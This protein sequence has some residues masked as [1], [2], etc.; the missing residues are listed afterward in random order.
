M[1][2]KNLQV[3]QIKIIKM[4]CK[5]PLKVC[6]SYLFKLLKHHLKKWKILQK[7][8]SKIMIFQKH[9]FQILIRRKGIQIQFSNLQD[10]SLVWE[11]FVVSAN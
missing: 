10:L 2:Q 1:I 6:K 7:I 5:R 4:Q 11:V 3:I 8:Q 9:Q